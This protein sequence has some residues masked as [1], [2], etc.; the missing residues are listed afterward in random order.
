MPSCTTVIVC[1]IHLDPRFTLNSFACLLKR[2][3]FLFILN[4]GDILQNNFRTL[5]L[6]RCG[7]SRICGQQQCSSNLVDKSGLDTFA[8]EV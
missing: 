6:F 8:V 3:I 1:K 7:E 2:F 5:F 4:K